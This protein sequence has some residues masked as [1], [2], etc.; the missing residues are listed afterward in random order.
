MIKSRDQVEGVFVQTQRKLMLLLND[1]GRQR[2]D[3]EDQALLHITSLI[4][5]EP[6][7]APRGGNDPSLT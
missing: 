2:G 5:S 3:N 4:S 1:V 7:P 6:D